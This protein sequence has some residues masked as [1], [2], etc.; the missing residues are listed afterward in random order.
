MLGNLA[1]FVVLPLFELPK[2]SEEEGEGGGHSP[3]C[4]GLMPSV[5]L[6]HGAFVSIPIYSGWESGAFRR[7]GQVEATP[8]DRFFLKTNVSVV[9]FG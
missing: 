6:R 1:L 7:S 8:N 3:P 9:A 5:R 4:A 2:P